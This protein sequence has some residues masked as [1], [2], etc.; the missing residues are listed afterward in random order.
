MYFLVKLK[1]KS[2]F[3]TMILLNTGR[4]LVYE[5]QTIYSSALCAKISS[6]FESANAENKNYF[7]LIQNS[8]ETRL[9]W[10]S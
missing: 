4:E 3:M 2:F 10:S 1:L 5:M 8:Y 7:S 9:G 6:N